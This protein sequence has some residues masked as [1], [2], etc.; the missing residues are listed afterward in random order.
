MASDKVT[1]K[2]HVLTV[3][4]LACL[5]ISIKIPRMKFCS[6]ATLTQLRLQRYLTD[7]LYR[8]E[9]NYALFWIDLSQFDLIRQWVSANTWHDV[10]MTIL[11]KGLHQSI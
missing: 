3:V 8:H 11:P 10:V 9:I 1:R 5:K 2:L 4:W 7:L 6:S